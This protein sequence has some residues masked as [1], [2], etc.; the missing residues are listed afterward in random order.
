MKTAP[1]DWPVLFV[2]KELNSATDDGFR[3]RELVHDLEQNQQC[4]VIPSFSYEDALEVFVS[5]A[6]IGV[7]VIDWDL[8]DQAK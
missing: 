7:V 3:L 5:R 4:Q 1:S 8:P 6:D 2:S